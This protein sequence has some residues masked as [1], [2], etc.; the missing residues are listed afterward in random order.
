VQRQ[1]S[2]PNRAS[3]S[4]QQHPNRRRVYPQPCGDLRGGEPTELDELEDFPL[5]WRQR[6]EVRGDE[7]LDARDVGHV[8]GCSRQIVDGHD[9]PREQSASSRVSATTFEGDVSRYAVQPGREPTAALELPDA[10]V[11]LHQHELGDILGVIVI[12]DD[13]PRPLSHTI[14]HATRQLVECR[15]IAAAHS[16]NE[17]CDLVVIA[18]A[19]DRDLHPLHDCGM[20]RVAWCVYSHEPF[21]L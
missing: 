19:R 10:L 18:W 6:V 13:A 2:F 17:R 21:G 8:V 1:Q 9:F 11:Q 5:P 7:A 15:G 3:C 12:G 20:V 4:Q 16:S 14:A